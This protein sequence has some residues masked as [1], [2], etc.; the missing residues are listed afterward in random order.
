MSS[1]VS[2]EI[3]GRLGVVTLNGPPVNALTIPLVDELRAAQDQLAR[4][5]VTV[6]AI[7]SL[8]PGFFMA[9]AD[10][11]DGPIEAFR[12]AV[13]CLDA[14][15]DSDLAT[16]MVFERAAVL[17]LFDS[18]DGREGIAAFLEKRLPSFGS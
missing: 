4:A 18:P 7:R 1:L 14:A 2:L 6:A 10:L 13:G 8:V 3:D 15:R 11:I 5:R 9:G 16:G 12:S 17:R